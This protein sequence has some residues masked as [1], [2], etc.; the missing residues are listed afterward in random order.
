MAQTEEVLDEGIQELVLLATG[1]SATAFSKIVCMTD[2]SACTAAKNHTHASPA[3]TLC[4]DTGLEE[5][6]INTV[7]QATTNTTGDTMTFDHVFTATGSKN[8]TGIHI[9]NTDG[10]RSFIECCFNAVLA[11]ENTD[12]LTIDGESTI[13]QA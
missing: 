3:D 10:D 13:D 1:G 7:S 4:T 8:V 5:A 2:S 12:T 9:C 11:M 6:A